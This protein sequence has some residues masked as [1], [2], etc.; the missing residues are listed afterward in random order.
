MEY[1]LLVNV[2]DLPV[3]KKIYALEMSM[4]VES[5]P[6]ICASIMSKN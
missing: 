3:D 1:V 4:T 5:L 6:L 2:S